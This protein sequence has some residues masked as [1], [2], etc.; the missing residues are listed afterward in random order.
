MFELCDV[1]QSITKYYLIYCD[2]I[3]EYRN[4]FEFLTGGCYRYKR[5]PMCSQLTMSFLIS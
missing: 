1:L 4:V 5:N 3:K 2:N